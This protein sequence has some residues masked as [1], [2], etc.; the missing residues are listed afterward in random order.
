MVKQIVKYCLIALLAL[1]LLDAS[2]VWGIAH[3]RPAIEKADSIVILGAAI[4]TP[5]LYN[6][7]LTGLELY[8]QGKADILILSGGKISDTDISE[9]EYMEKVININASSEVNYVLEEDSHNTYENIRNTKE[10][11]L[12][13][14]KPLDSIIIVSDAFHLARAFLLAKRAGFETVYWSAP[15]Q[16]YYPKE[17]LRFY[18]IREFIAMF[19][20]IPKFIFG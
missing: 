19:S 3:N 16:D 13:T 12:V 2:L 10:H 14:G 11:L 4:N 9:A 18:Y 20:Y 8:E 17:E 7:T 15:S 5:A 1:V 6:R